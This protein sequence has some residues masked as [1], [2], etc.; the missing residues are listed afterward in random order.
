[1]RDERLGFL[2]LF[3]LIS[4][5]GQLVSRE[6]AYLK[7]TQFVLIIRINCIYYTRRTVERVVVVL[8]II[9]YK[10]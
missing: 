2:T 4:I 1:M 10:I 6:T 8:I 7:G 9:Q 5:K 3:K